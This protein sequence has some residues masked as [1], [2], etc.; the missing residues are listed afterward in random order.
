MFNASHVGDR[1]VNRSAVVV[2]GTSGMGFAT[3]AMLVQEC[4]AS[5]IL[6]SR[7][8]Q[9]GLL[10]QEVLEQIARDSS[11]RCGVV[12]P[13]IQFVQ[14]DATNRASVQRMFAASKIRI[15]VVV[16]T[17][18]IPGWTGDFAAIPNAA[19]LGRHDAVFN[20][21]YGGVFV[22]QETLRYWKSHPSTTVTHDALVLVSSEQGMSPCPAC[23]MYGMSKHGLVGLATSLAASFSASPSP[24]VSVVLPGLV[25][26]P[27]T[28]NQARGQVVRNGTLVPAPGLRHPLQIWQCVSD[29]KV[30]ENGNCPNGEGSGYGCPCPDVER[31][32]P[33]VALL[34]KALLPNQQVSAMIS[35]NAVAMEILSL[36]AAKN[37]EV[38]VVPNAKENDGRGTPFTRT[39]SPDMWK[40]CPADDL[41]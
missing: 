5:I 14:M 33:R 15:D 30:I 24:S 39:C 23:S 19:F 3:A 4:V 13:S 29:G 28:W 27:F 26:T 25:D 16:H 12:L 11:P 41:R 35:P 17:A 1:F 31:D 34:A 38:R 18:A 8:L 7:N 21:L 9:Q 22:L 20:N 6:G 40:L 37:G 2:G 10:A 32:D 36:L